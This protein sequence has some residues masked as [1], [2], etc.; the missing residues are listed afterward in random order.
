MKT[1]MNLLAASLFV[2]VM[3]AHAAAE[4]NKVKIA[5]EKPEN[6]AHLEIYNDLKEHKVLERLQEFF[7][8]FKLVIPVE[9]VV[10][11]CDGEPEA[12]Y[13][14]GEILICYEFIEML[15]QN[16]PEETTPGGIEPADTVVG[17]FFDTVL[18]EFSHALFDMFYTPIFGREEDAADQLAAYLYLQ[19]GE[20]EAR[21]LILG[22]AYNYL[23]V[24]TSDE[25][26][27]QT[28]EEFIEDSAETHS[29]PSQRAYNLLCMAYG[30]NPRLFA[31]LVSKNHLPDHRAEFCEEEYEQVQQAYY[32]LIE[33]HTDPDLVKEVFDRSWLRKVDQGRWRK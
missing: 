6:S 23:V 31:D 11:G 3:T 20:D 12:E 9:I 7:S 22:T 26:S 32:D 21:R 29:L 1:I 27:A 24:E 4:A 17:P 10:E 8:P 14:D 15:I 33:P 19:L 16:M 30:A 5:Y 18:H 13:G 28:A 2:S 25:D